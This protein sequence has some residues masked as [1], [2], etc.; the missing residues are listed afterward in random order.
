MNTLD[1]QVD[2][3]QFQGPSSQAQAKENGGYR[4]PQEPANTPSS[5][6][7]SDQ[8]FM[9]DVRRQILE[10]SQRIQVLVAKQSGR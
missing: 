7:K 4:M 1:G 5:V 2:S 8:E 9:R 6:A 3:R 10:L